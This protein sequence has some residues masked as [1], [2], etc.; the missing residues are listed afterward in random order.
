[1]V[2]IVGHALGVYKYS[3]S[4][5][6]QIHYS[7]SLPL[8]F[9]LVMTRASEHLQVQTPSV[10]HH[11]PRRAVGHRFNLMIKVKISGTVYGK[12]LV[13]RHPLA[14]TEGLLFWIHQNSLTSLGTRDK[15]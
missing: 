11:R 12:R 1:M 13:G 7:Y 6:S 3:S 8:L 14:S 15:E 10:D 2:I 5:R 4:L 9:V